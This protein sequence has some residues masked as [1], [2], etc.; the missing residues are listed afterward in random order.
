MLLWTTTKTLCTAILSLAYSTT[1]Y[2]T[3]A[4]YCSAHTHLIHS[5]LNDA[6]CIATGCLCPTPTD[7]LPILSGIQPAEHYQLGA[8]FFLDYCGS[9][10]PDLKMIIEL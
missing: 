2:C 4:W 6:L 10:D 8:T 7:H 9:L 1:E 3:P 5:A